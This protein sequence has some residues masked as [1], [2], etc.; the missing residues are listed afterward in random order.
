MRGTENGELNRVLDLLSKIGKSTE[1]DIELHQEINPEQDVPLKNDPVDLPE[2]KK[3]YRERVERV[4]EEL[5]IMVPAEPIKFTFQT[6]TTTKKSAHLNS[7]EIELDEN[8]L[9]DIEYDQENNTNRPEENNQTDYYIY[10]EQSSAESSKELEKF[11][12]LYTSLKNSVENDSLGQG[13]DSINQVYTEINGN[14]EEIGCPD[15]ITIS[16]KRKFDEYSPEDYSIFYAETQPEQPDFKRQQLDAEK[17]Y[18]DTNHEHGFLSLDYNPSKGE[19][20]N[21]ESDTEWAK[22]DHIT[23]KVL[24]KLA[25]M[26]QNPDVVAKIKSLRDEQVL[27][28]H[29][30][31]L[32]S[33][34]IN[35]MFS[36]L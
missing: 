25:E 16:S 22:I 19:I 24:V 35:R 3:V 8:E 33:H 6:E 28:K 29:I 32:I 4:D 23:P 18:T 20:T 30:S 26:M 21:Y 14:F 2:S 11:R 13:I 34:I 15:E 17:Y 12:D 31:F 10:K 36:F 5:N 1:L 9:E 27:I 7:D